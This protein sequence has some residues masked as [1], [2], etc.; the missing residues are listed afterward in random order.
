MLIGTNI[1]D[2]ETY[3][4]L[5][6]A[7]NFPLLILS[8]AGCNFHL[9]FGKTFIYSKYTP[10]KTDSEGMSKKSVVKPPEVTFF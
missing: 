5:Q 1:C 8:M 9:Y 7:S 4:K 2:V 6:K 3:R 10:G